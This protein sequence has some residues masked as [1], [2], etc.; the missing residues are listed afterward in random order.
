MKKYYLILFL[1]SVFL[2]SIYAQSPCDPDGIHPFCTEANPYGVTYYTATSGSADDFLGPNGYSCLY[3][4]PAPAYYYLRIATP[5][6]LLIYIEQQSINGGYELDVDFACWGPFQANTQEQFIQNLC[7]GGYTLDDQDMGSH[8]VYDGYHSPTDPTTWGGYPAGNVV[9]CSFDPSG[10]EWCYIPNAQVGEYYLIILTNFSLEAGIIT[11]NREN[12]SSATTDC[13]LL[14]PVS[15]NGP[16]CAGATLYLTCHNSEAGATYSWTGPNGWTSNLQNPVIQNTTTSMSGEYTLTMIFDGDTG[17]ASTTVLITTQPNIVIT[18]SLQGL[19]AGDTVTFTASGGTT[20]LWSTGETTPS[21]T[22]SPTV[23][24]VYTVTG[25]ANGGCS[26]TATAT[27]ELGQASVVTLSSPVCEGKPITVSPNSP[28]Y[29]YLWNT[30]ETSPSIFPD[31]DIPTTYTVTVT[32]AYGCSGTASVVVNPSPAA[33]FAISQA[34]LEIENGFAVANFTNLSQDADIWA[35][36]F[37]DFNATGNQSSEMS[38][39]YS[40]THSGIYT[41]WL[42]VSTVENCKDSISRVVTVTTPFEF[43]I[44]N[45]FTPNIN[46]LNE[47]F[48]PTGVGVSPNNY[49]MSIYNSFGELIYYTTEL[50]GTWDGKVK[51]KLVPADVYVYHFVIESIDGFQRKYTG[52]VTVIR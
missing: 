19:C 15:N 41:V 11:F 30:G 3:S 10:Y 32:D 47:V 43:Y 27:A 28:Q 24:T 12:V 18:P 17:V 46:G 25:T 45:A 9:D 1:I 42:V 21:I 34:E 33:D 49:E 20:Y 31:I 39:S 44:P 22:V 13:S 50:Y 51:G 5:G 2:N 29:T 52:T 23:T 35:W 6:D 8:F 4:Y 48:A 38:P 37:G 36:N 7:S 26:A 40:Y 16:L 14:A